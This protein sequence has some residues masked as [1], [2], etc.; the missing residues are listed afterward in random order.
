MK[1]SICFNNSRH[2]IITKL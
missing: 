1:V 2:F